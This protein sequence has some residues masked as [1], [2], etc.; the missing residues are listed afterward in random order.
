MSDGQARPQCERLDKLTELRRHAA[1]TMR[2]FSTLGHIAVALV[3]PSG[4]A[5]TFLVIGHLPTDWQSPHPS[6]LLME[7]GL[8]AIM[9]LMAVINRYAFVPL[10]QERKGSY[11]RY[12]N[13]ER[14]KRIAQEIIVDQQQE[15]RH[16]H[17]ARRSVACARCRSDPGRTAH[18]DQHSEL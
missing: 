15:I 11:L 2:R 9:T 16:A 6:K 1:S 10:L 4:A 12:G 7:I 14:L 18:C 17:G 5:N 3:L 13:D 8:V